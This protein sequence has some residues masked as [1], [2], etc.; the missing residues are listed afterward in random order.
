MGR[1]EG[2]GLSIVLEINNTYLVRV[3]VHGIRLQQTC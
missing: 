1:K 2:E 3:V